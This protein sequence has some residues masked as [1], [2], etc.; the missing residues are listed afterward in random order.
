MDIDFTVGVTIY[1]DHPLHNASIFTNNNIKLK[2]ATNHVEGF[3]YY[4]DHITGGDPEDTFH[5]NYNPSGLLGH[6]HVD[7]IEIPDVKVKEFRSLATQTFHGDL[8][9]SGHYDLGTRENPFI[10][11]VKKN[12]KT[13]GDVTFSGY[14]VILV[15]KKIVLG[16][17]LMPLDGPTDESSLGLY[18]N[19]K[20]EFKKS[21]FIAA[22]LFAGGDVTF[23]KPITLYGSITTAKKVVFTNATELHYRPASSALTE[24][25]WPINPQ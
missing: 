15:E 19:G 20:I 7:P 14:G 24:P 1:S 16:H 9:L 21:T 2:G 13:D 22:Q 25:L 10:W 8:K 4:V 11:Y 5:P 6:Q 12:L 3:G 17:H 18:T 23:K